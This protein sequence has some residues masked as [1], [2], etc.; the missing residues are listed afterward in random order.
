MPSFRV[1]LRE[2]PAHW[3]AVSAFSESDEASYLAMWWAKDGWR[4]CFV[5]TKGREPHDTDENP[6]IIPWHMVSYIELVPY[7]IVTPDVTKQRETFLHGKDNDT[8]H[9][10]TGRAT[11]AKD[12]E[13]TL[14]SALA[15]LRGAHIP[16][17]PRADRE[18]D[19]SGGREIRGY[20][21]GPAHPYWPWAG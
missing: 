6:M 13:G 8:T 20:P 2:K 11:Q 21:T 17:S 10:A 5:I 12:I 15:R 7:P 4:Q 1:H 14:W 19:R 3:M 16:S 9:G 18:D